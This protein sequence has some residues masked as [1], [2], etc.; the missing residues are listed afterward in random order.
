[1]D[2]HSTEALE[3]ESLKAQETE[4]K[5]HYTPRPKSQV[6]MAWVL[7]GVVIFAVLGMCYWEIF[8]RF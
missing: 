2:E 5:K 4:E 3:S 7:L 6:V 8:G 1:M